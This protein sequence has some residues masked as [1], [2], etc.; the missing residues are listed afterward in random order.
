VQGSTSACP[1]PGTARQK[2]LHKEV[3]ALADRYASQYKEVPDDNFFKA[4]IGK[5][6]IKAVVD[7]TKP[8]D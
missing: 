1:G 7:E 5:V 3:K 4:Y 8:L 2:A 6:T